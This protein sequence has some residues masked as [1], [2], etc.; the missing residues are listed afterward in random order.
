MIVELLEEPTGQ[1]AGSQ[2]TRERRRSRRH[3]VA[4]PATLTAVAGAGA[5]VDPAP[6][7]P[8]RVR[9][10]SLH[11]AGLRCDGPFAEGAEFYLDIGAGLLKLH[12][13][14][15]V[16]NVRLRRDGSWDVGTAFSLG[17]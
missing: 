1:T 12:A 11:G 15:R 8:V 13:R 3:G 17:G 9:D 4:L 16:M 7:I 2:P 5:G 14:V 10:I 6:A